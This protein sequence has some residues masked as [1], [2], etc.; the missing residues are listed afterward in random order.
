MTSPNATFTTFFTLATFSTRSFLVSLG[1]LASLAFLSGCDAAD[2]ASGDDASR[3]AQSDYSVEVQVTDGDWDIAA[4]KVQW[5][6]E[7]QL[8]LL[9]IGEVI[10]TLGAT[11]VGTPYVPHVLEAEG[12]ER[13][14]VNLR[15]LDC[16]TFVEHILVLSR[17]VLSL[18]DEAL[19]DE[20][21]FRAH[22][23]D[24]L[25]R[26]RYRD[27]VL[28]GYP[29]RLHYFSEWLSDA[30][31]KGLVQQVTAE[32]GGE[33]LPGAI[34][35]MS[36]HPDAYRQLA[37][38]ENLRAIEEIEARLSGETRH[39]IPQDRIA[40]VA[41]EIRNGDIIAATSTVEGLDIAHTGI[42]LWQGGELHLLHAPLI[43]SSVEISERP[44]ADRIQLIRG[45]DGI[46]VAR[47]MEPESGA[48]GRGSPGTPGSPEA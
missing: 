16:V 38:S 35:F 31:R 1:V 25:T 22:Y 48:Q 36:T 5:A 3:A 17:L 47:P 4:V 9:P 30:E 44:L 20:A 19:E 11:F 34:D 13:L 32:L 37:D 12:P 18:P 23:V 43:G 28:N 33:P 40:Q 27:G 29:D 24:A 8:E 39:Y 42:A 41:D 21:L 7:Q 46:M 10:A 26:V 15:Q 2:G 45:Q 14:I 6:R